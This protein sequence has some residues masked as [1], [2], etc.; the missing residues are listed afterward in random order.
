MTRD[1]SRKTGITRLFTYL[2][3]VATL[4]PRLVHSCDFVSS[5]GCSSIRFAI[6]YSIASSSINVRP[7]LHACR[8]TMRRNLDP[9][10]DVLRRI[11]VARRMDTQ[12]R[13]EMAVRKGTRAAAKTRPLAVEKGM[14]ES[15]SACLN[16]FSLLV[17]LNARS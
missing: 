1:P 6:L 5:R 7:I 10:L 13:L 8:I 16:P 3:I 15:V 4:K 14:L 12:I 17:V 9:F 11:K 2:S